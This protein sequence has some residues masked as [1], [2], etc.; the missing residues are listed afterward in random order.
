MAE[1]RLA[2][3][4][5][6]FLVGAVGTAHA[7]VP[8]SCDAFAASESAASAQSSGIRIVGGVEASRVWVTADYQGLRIQKFTAKGGASVIE[9]SYQDDS[10]VLSLS[11]ERISVGRNGVARELSAPDAVE[12]VQALLAG[13]P[14]MFQTRVMLS[15]LER[16]SAL[17]AGSMTILSAAAFAASLTGDVNAPLRLAERFVEK[18]RAPYRRARHDDEAS[19]WSS[20]SQE[21][22]NALTDATACTKEALEAGGIWTLG[23]TYACSASWALRVESAWFEYLKCLSPLGSVSKFE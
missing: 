3:A 17:K 5:A 16:T 13:S 8:D 7:D 12:Q 22:D 14:A 20:Y 9:F 11:K 6:A 4:V 19:C 10:V 21:V 23:R 15:Q 2:V 18:H 1:K